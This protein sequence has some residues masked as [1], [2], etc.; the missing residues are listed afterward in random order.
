MPVV[1]TIFDPAETAVFSP[2]TADQEPAI[3]AADGLRLIGWTATEAGGTG[4]TAEVHLIHGETVAGGTELESI[5]FAGDESKHSWQWPGV[6]ADN[7]ISIEVVD[8]E[9]DIEI[10][11]LVL[12]I[13]R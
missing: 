6:R 10:Y 1:K 12:P 9:V 2:I 13:D 3:A 8:G 5:K 7:G 4:A 11:Y